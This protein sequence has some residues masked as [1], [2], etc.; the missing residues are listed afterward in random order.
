MPEFRKHTGKGHT[1][2]EHDPPTA[3]TDI[4]ILIAESCYEIS[5]TLLRQ[6]AY[7]NEISVYFSGYDRSTAHGGY[8]IHPEGFLRYPIELF[9]CIESHQDIESLILSL[10]GGIRRVQVNVEC[11]P[12]ISPLFSDSQAILEQ[13]SL[14]EKIRNKEGEEDV[15]GLGL[16]GFRR[17]RISTYTAKRA[18]EI[19]RARVLLKTDPIISKLMAL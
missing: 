13:F 4:W 17:R 6:N 18:D 14:L 9:I 15:I 19:H 1:L 7:A 5:R 10:L 3:P 2:F 16:E 11:K 12:Y 8:L